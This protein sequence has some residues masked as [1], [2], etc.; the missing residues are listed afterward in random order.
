MTSPVRFHEALRE[1]L[2]GREGVGILI[3]LGPSG[4][5]AGPIGQIKQDVADQG[6]NNISCST[7]RSRFGRMWR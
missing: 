3:E 2:S 4:A 6:T 5:L 1:M 7:R